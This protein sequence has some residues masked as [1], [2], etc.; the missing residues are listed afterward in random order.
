LQGFC[1]ITTGS[2]AQSEINYL[3]WVVTGYNF[4]PCGVGLLG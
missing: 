2:P 3:T 1:A 4:M